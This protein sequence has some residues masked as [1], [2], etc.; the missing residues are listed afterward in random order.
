[1]KSVN[2]I[3]TN[4]QDTLLDG[5][6]APGTSGFFEIIIDASKAEVGIDYDVQFVNETSK[7]SN[8]LFKCNETQSY[9]L[10]EMENVLKG[11]INKDDQEK[12][13]IYA[14]EWEWKYETGENPQ[15]IQKN[16]EIDTKN[17]LELENYSFDIEV[18]GT[19]MLPKS[20]AVN[21]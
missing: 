3:D 10:K 14:I 6:I 12:I 15:S 11:S 16:D 2:L 21:S 9:T 4:K 7:P 20:T 8:L 19:Q 13:K 1:M 18:T 17:G 5:K